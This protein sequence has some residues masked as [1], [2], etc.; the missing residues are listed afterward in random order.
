MNSTAFRPTWSS[1]P[2]LDSTACLFLLQI[3]NLNAPF[4]SLFHLVDTTPA[5]QRFYFIRGRTSDK[6]VR[7]HPGPTLF[8]VTSFLSLSLPDLLLCF[9]HICNFKQFSDQEILFLLSKFSFCFLSMKFVFPPPP[10]FVR[11]YFNPSFPSD[12]FQRWE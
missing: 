9:S 5:S 4:L 1:S 11:C 8:N 12:S 6:N 10:F 2:S 7:N 3:H